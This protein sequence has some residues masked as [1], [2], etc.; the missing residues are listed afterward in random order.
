MNTQTISIK[1]IAEK[2]LFNKNL[3]SRKAI[4]EKYDKT[5]QGN[6]T[7]ARGKAEASIIEPFV[8]FP[9]LT[10]KNSKIG[11][12][13]AIAGNPLY[14]KISAYL[15]GKNAVLESVA[16]IFAVGGKPICITDCLNFGNPEIPKAMNDF[17]DGVNGVANISK[18]L[19]I[20]IVSG[21]V[22]FYNESENSSI[23]PSVSIFTLGKKKPN[24][25]K[26]NNFIKKNTNNC[27]IILVGKRKNELGASIFY[28]LLNKVGKNLP[29]KNSKEFLEECDFIHTAISTKLIQASKFIGTGG[30]FFALASFAIKSKCGAEIFLDKIPDYNLENFKKLF[31][32]TFGFLLF[33]QNKDIIKF[34]K[35]MQNFDTNFTII[36]E[37]NFD[38][39]NL[40]FLNKKNKY[41][42]MDLEPQK[43]KF[44]NKLFD[45]YA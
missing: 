44:Y 14:G 32:E 34:K 15:Q 25:S 35:K 6:T 18:K 5:V 13:T 3:I 20:P 27:K 7:L 36:G 19:N 9:E 1:K 11:L 21:N 16:R 29:N 31:S 45:F 24:I 41:F 28:N 26:I 2:L 37:T 40:N 4:Y 22:S 17:A 39:K 10:N 12:V 42:N 23:L 38:S 8:D 43:N 33:V 30:L